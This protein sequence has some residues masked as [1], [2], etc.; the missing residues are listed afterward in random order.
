MNESFTFCPMLV[1][2]IAIFRALTCIGDDFVLVIKSDIN[3][4]FNPLNPDYRKS[5]TKLFLK[6]F[7]IQQTHCNKIGNPLFGMIQVARA[8]HLIDT[9]VRNQDH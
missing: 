9:N 8:Y 5:C 4:G 6:L 1:R 7:Y 2:R 3:L